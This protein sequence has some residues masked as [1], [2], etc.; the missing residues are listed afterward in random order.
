MARETVI[1]EFGGYTVGDAEVIDISEMDIHMCTGCWSCWVST[2][3]R[4][5][6][7][8]LDRF[9]HA[10]ITSDRLI[11]FIRAE[12]GFVSVR[13]KKLMDRMCPLFMPYIKFADGG[14]WHM[15][16]YDSYPDVE[17]FYEG[18][19]VSDEE[20]NNFCEYVRW[21]FVQFHSENISVRPISEFAEVKQ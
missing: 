15:K 14:S 2:P 4:C 6:F 18:D 11:F 19:F 3:G 16:R 20:R 9:Y 7:T 1:R 13:F 17:V 21:I 8:D 5:V 10:Y 12:K